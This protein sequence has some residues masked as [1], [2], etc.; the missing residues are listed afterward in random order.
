MKAVVRVVSFIVMVSVFLMIGGI[1][2]LI[3]AAVAGF[4][5]DVVLRVTFAV[6]PDINEQPDAPLSTNPTAETDVPHLYKAEAKPQ[7][8]PFQLDPVTVLDIAEK[9]KGVEGFFIAPDIDQMKYATAV[10]ALAVPDY[11]IVIALI[12]GTMADDAEF[13]IIIGTYGIYVR[14]QRNGNAPEVGAILYTDLVK[15]EVKNLGIFDIQLDD[16]HRFS[17]VGSEMDRR[18]MVQLLN[19]LRRATKRALD[20]TAEVTQTAE[21]VVVEPV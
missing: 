5:T 14:T 9:Y 12:D 4:V 13:G 15:N 16:T 19:K 1:V 2:G 6:D 20:P 21:M 7:P 8:P 10:A 3:V 11:E 18:L 17:T